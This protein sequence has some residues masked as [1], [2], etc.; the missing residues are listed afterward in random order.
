MLHSLAKVGNEKFDKKNRIFS[1]LT[2]KGGRSYPFIER[3]Y[4]RDM[5]RSQDQINKMLQKRQTE[6][7]TNA[8][9]HM[10]VRN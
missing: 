9:F 6:C 2:F 8:V 5:V 3:L 4:S 10:T 7:E 1:S